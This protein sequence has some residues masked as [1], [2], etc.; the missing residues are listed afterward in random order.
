MVAWL[1]AALV[2]VIN[3]YL[4]FDFFASEVT[5]WLFSVGVS[6]FTSGYVAFIVYLVL[7]GINFSSCCG[8]K[9]SMIQ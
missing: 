5:G 3:G 8:S 7:R 6:A 2:M 4:L 9:R 1:V